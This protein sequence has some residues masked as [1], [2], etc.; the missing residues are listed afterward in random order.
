MALTAS[1]IAAL[2][3]LPLSVPQVAK[4]QTKG[5]ALTLG[6]EIAAI[7]AGLTPSVVTSLQTAAEVTAVADVAAVATANSAV[8]AVADAVGDVGAGALAN[9]LKAKYNAAVTLINELKTR[10]A[11]DRALINDLKAKYNA[12]ATGIDAL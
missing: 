4:D 8:T 7:A 1:Q 10:Q 3:K 2:D 5:V 6:T 11:E 9:D 12:L